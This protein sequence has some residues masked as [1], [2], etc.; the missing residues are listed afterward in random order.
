MSDAGGELAER[1]QLLGLD[2]SVLRDTQVVERSG[3]FFGACLQL[4]EQPG[5]FDR[6][7]CLIGK[8]LEQRQL[9]RC[10][11]AGLG[12]VD[13]DR[14]D[15]SAALQ[16]RCC[17]QTAKAGLL[18]FDAFVSV[19]GLDIRNLNSG[20]GLLDLGGLALVLLASGWRAVI[21][22]SCSNRLTEPLAYWPPRSE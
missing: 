8:R 22:P 6:N 5:V 4:V 11:R 20:A 2:Q 21:D 10:E 7:N 17:E 18:R 15:G 3:K 14:P 1:R 13:Y 16:K 12:S 9:S 19:I